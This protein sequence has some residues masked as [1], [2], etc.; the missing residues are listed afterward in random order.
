VPDV[1]DAIFAFAQL[2]GAVASLS[3]RSEGPAQHPELIGAIMDPAD[4]LPPTDAST[5]ALLEREGHVVHPTWDATRRELSWG[6]EL[7][8]R[9]RQPAP[10]QACVLAA[11]DAQGWP[12][13][14]DDPLPRGRGI[15]SK[16]HLRDT[17]K[18]LNRH[19]RVR[20]IVFEADGT[21]GG[22]MWRPPVRSYPRATPKL[23]Q[24]NG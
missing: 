10:S 18:N 24:E 9:F 11:L 21:G 17:I 5:A 6:A 15:N 12:P 13:R 23:P 19:Q 7:I 20:R 14:I 16:Q 3:L 22:I 8:K 1:A 4:L 2:S